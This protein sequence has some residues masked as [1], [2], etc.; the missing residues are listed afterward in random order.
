[1]QSADTLEVSESAESKEASDSLLPLLLQIFQ[2]KVIDV[3]NS[4][5]PKPVLVNN[6]YDRP[7]SEKDVQLLLQQTILCSA[8]EPGFVSP[9][10][11]LPVNHTFGMWVF[12]PAGVNDGILFVKG[13]PVQNS[14]NLEPWSRYS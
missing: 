14:T 13:G 9:Y 3:V 2:A 10:Q 11:F 8:T 1:M 6:A 7:K 4:N 12:R 5:I